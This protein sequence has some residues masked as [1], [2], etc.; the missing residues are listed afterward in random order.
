M[1]TEVVSPFTCWRCDKTLADAAGPGTSV[2]CTRCGARN[3]VPLE[4]GGTTKPSEQVQI[5]R[6]DT[7]TT[8][9]ATHPAAG[10]PPAAMK[11]RAAAPPLP[12]PKGKPRK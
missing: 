8:P 4:P 11:N 6:D 12:R 1:V 3:N 9:A 5:A 2:R 7:P 10:R